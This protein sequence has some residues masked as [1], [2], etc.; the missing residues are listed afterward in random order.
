MGK[1]IDAKS[2]QEEGW[3]MSNGYLFKGEEMANHILLTF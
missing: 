3:R 1:N 2:S